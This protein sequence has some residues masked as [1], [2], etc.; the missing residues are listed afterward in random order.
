M[1]AAYTSG[2]CASMAAGTLSSDRPGA[3][4]VLRAARRWRRASSSSAVNA[5]SAFTAA[6]HCASICVRWACDWAAPACAS[7]CVAGAVKPA[8]LIWPVRR[9]VSSREVASAPAMSSEERQL[10]SPKY[11][12]A[13]SAASDTRASCHCAC[14]P[15]SRACAARL[16]W[17]R[18]PNRSSSHCAC[19]P[20]CPVVTTVPTRPACVDTPRCTPACASR[21]GSMAASAPTAPAR[22]CAM[23]AAAPA[24]VGLA[25]CAASIRSTSSGSSQRCHQSSSCGTLPP[26]GS[27]ATPATWG[28]RHWAGAIAS[29]CSGGAV[30]Q[31][32]STAATDR[33]ARVR[34][35]KGFMDQLR[36]RE[37]AGRA[38]A[39][40]HGS[41]PGH[42]APDA[43]RR[44]RPGWAPAAGRG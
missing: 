28:A 23:R 17:R 32:A 5:T 36:K 30:A 3:L 13:T 37:T 15:C 14:A 27:T 39:P 20:A 18:P 24:S 26:W 35:Y 16:P 31:P 43:P 42:S 6:L 12:L 29:A 19:T 21:F 4:P 44:A 25:C 10:R 40:R 2:R 8:L 22:A 11:W 1:A 7:A 41:G 33:A 34:I 38:G 9:A